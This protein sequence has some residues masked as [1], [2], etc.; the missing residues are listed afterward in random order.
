MKLGTGNRDTYTRRQEG[1]R[2]GK[3][4]YLFRHGIQ[5]VR[6]TESASDDPISTDKIS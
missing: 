4:T 1:T 2:E 6:K 5:A 3:R